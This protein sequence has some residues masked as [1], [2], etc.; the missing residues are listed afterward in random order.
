M[1]TND[2]RDVLR[3]AINSDFSSC[4][5]GTGTFA[6]NKD[7]TGLFF[8]IAVTLNTLSTKF[9]SSNVISV[10]HVID[11]T[12]ANSSTLS[13]WEI[14]GNSDAVNYNRIVTNGFLKDSQTEITMIQVFSLE[15]I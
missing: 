7:Q 4:Q 9:K 11:I 8:P 3:D 15:R 6:F 13:E 12:E 5:A 2:G 10:T 1:M 14:L